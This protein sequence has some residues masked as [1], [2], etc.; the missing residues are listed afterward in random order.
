MTWPGAPNSPAACS[1]VGR[2]EI[3]QIVLDLP[4]S[5]SP[6]TGSELMAIT[7][8]LERLG[9][10]PNPLADPRIHLFL[11]EDVP[12]RNSGIPRPPETTPGPAPV[13]SQPPTT[14]WYPDS[15]GGPSRKFEAN[16]PEYLV[17]R[18]RRGLRLIQHRIYLID[19]CL[20][21]TGLAIRPA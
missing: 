4:S 17:Q 1:T 18:I 10:L 21:E 12:G 11:Q 9:Q 3:V 20:A 19:G 16:I 2:K 13:R 6:A 15:V 14:K 8:A 5:A 7:D